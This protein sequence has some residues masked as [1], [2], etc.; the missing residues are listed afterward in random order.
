M[1]ARALSAG[2]AIAVDVEQRR[3]PLGADPYLVQ[4]RREDVGTFLI[5]THALPDLSVLQRG[6]EDVCADCLQDLPNLTGRP[7]LSQ[8]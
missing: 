8:H 1:A 2:S 6:V 5:I 4:I 7:P 3:V